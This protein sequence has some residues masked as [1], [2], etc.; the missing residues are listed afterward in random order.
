MTETYPRAVWISLIVATCVVVLA[1]TATIY[2]DTD[3][4]NRRV[5]ETEREC[6]RAGNSW[7]NG[8]CVG[9]RR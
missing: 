5:Q 7:V 1:I 4:Q 2:V 8:A 9:S 3:R 6:I